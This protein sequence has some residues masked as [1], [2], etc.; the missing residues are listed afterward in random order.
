MPI[1]YRALVSALLLIFMCA[2]PLCA[3]E[4]AG[5]DEFWIIWERELSAIEPCEE[6]DCSHSI[7]LGHFIGDMEPKAAQKFFS[8][9]GR[10]AAGPGDT[11]IRLPENALC[12][13]GDAHDMPDPTT[14]ERADKV[15]TLRGLTGVHVDLRGVRGPQSFKGS[16]G[17]R[18]QAFMLRIFEEHD[19]PILTKEAAQAS[20][21]NAVLSMRYS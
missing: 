4:N 12:F 16:F 9:L 1:R 10:F 20:P 3:Q 21:G 5:T 6:E 14:L 17:E 8:G 2:T 19:I 13:A 15:D 18:A 11:H 7:T